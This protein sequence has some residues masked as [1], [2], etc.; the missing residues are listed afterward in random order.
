M[1]ALG[2]AMLSAVFLIAI[3]MDNSQPSSTP[4]QT[5]L[6][7][8][9]YLVFSATIAL[10]TWRN[11]WIDARLAMSA[12]LVDMAAFALICFSVSGYTS[13]FF[14][15][16]V[17]PLMSAAIRWGWRETGATAIA[18]VLLFLS[19]GFLVSGSEAFEVQRFVVRAGHLAILSGILIWFGIHQRFASLYLPLDEYDSVIGD[20]DPRE[21]AL[22]VTM[23]AADASTGLLLTYHPDTGR[24]S[25]ISI[26]GG[27]THVVEEFDRFVTEPALGSSILFDARKDRALSKT[28]GA[29]TIFAPLSS[30]V[31]RGEIR[32]LGLSEGLI[33][34]ISASTVEGWLILEGIPDLSGDYVELGLELGRAAGT[35]L[36][37]SALL[38][39]MA[40]GAAANTRLALA[41]D[42]HDSI[43]Q[44]IA[45]AT[46]RVEAIARAAR[47]GSDVDGELKELKNLLVDEQRDIRGFVNALRRD[48]E[49]PLADAVE[50]LRVLAARLGQHWAVKCQVAARE[51][52]VPIPIRLQFDLHHLLREAVANAVRHGGADRIDVTLDVEGD[53]LRFDVLDNGRGF[54][55]ADGNS[56]AQPWSL[57]ERVERANGSLFLVSEPGRTNVTINLPLNGAA[58]A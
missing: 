51:R 5:Y 31:E 49:L 37:R 39:A 42:V 16:F 45:G 44:F 32:R 40:E 52:E 47:S 4:G 22:R 2:R 13:P 19:G 7:L 17:L 43:V 9:F 55:V 1:I 10:V 41:R 14:L 57:R 29:R 56:P 18:L 48:S 54:A 34:R 58:A 30:V 24:L 53:V 46:F 6:V 26:E 12:H 36:D 8:L 20:G 50:E 25:G 27:V 38:A 3:W 21:L 11:W 15:V 33:A 23:Q 28:A 35:L